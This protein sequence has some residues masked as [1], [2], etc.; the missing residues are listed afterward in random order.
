MMPAAALFA[1][2][3]LSEVWPVKGGGRKMTWELCSNVLLQSVRVGT[4]GERGCARMRA[5]ACIS[6]PDPRRAR[7]GPT[8][9]FW[10]GAL[11]QLLASGSICMCTLTEPESPRWCAGD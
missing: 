4:L 9:W 11:K 10:I 5:M 1:S 6:P 7:L 2:H 8:L 3:V